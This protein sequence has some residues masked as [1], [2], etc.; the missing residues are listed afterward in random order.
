MTYATLQSIREADR[1]SPPNNQSSVLGLSPDGNGAGDSDI[2]V[3]RTWLTWDPAKIG[4]PGHSGGN[5]GEAKGREGRRRIGP[6][7]VPGGE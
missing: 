6:F 7:R 2:D 1:I 3:G 5:E 4:W